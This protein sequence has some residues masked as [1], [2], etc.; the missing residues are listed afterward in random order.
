MAWP[1]LIRRSV[2]TEK[3]ENVV[4][5]PS[6]PIATNGRTYRVGGQRSSTNVN[7]S[8]STNDPETLM[9]NVAHGNDPVAAGNRSLSS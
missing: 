9:Q 1:F 6:T 2:S 5:A 3:V 7:T 8:P 4:Y